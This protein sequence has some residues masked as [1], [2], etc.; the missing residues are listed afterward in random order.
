MERWVG[1]VEVGRECNDLVIQK[2]NVMTI[3]PSN[4]CLQKCYNTNHCLVYQEDSFSSN[5]SILKFLT[6]HSFRSK[7]LNWKR[8]VGMTVDCILYM[9]IENWRA[10]STQLIDCSR[11]YRN[12][13]ISF[14]RKKSFVWL[15]FWDAAKY[16]ENISPVEWH[17]K[18]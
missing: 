16:C 6:L 9:K 14:H 13:R 12:D 2:I 11:T 7:L 15:I 5:N 3:K 4:S 10:L 8:D 18:F 1:R 17:N